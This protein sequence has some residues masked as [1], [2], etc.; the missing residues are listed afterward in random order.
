MKLEH[1][2]LL[3]AAIPP[4]AVALLRFGGGVVLSWF[5]MGWRCGPRN[6]MDVILIVL[7]VVAMYHCTKVLEQLASVHPSKSVAYHLGAI[8]LMLAMFI[9]PCAAFLYYTLGSWH[10]SVITQDGYTIVRA[11]NG[12]GSMGEV[13]CFLPINSLVH[14]MELDYDWSTL[15]V[16]LPSEI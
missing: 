8:V 12:H 9:L 14:G 6:I 5:G 16:K 3:R 1:K 7:F 13:R 10:D 11:S 15:Q 2:R 4:A